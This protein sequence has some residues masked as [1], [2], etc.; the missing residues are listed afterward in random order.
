MSFVIVLGT[1]QLRGLAPCSG[2][3]R[4]CNLRQSLKPQTATRSM[5]R[6]IPCRNSQES[7]TGAPF[8]AKPLYQK[9]AQYTNNRTYVLLKLATTSHKQPTRSE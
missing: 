7:G 6:I 8:S 9:S 4:C 3:G 5:S 2:R 1:T